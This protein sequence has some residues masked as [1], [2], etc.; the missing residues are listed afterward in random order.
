MMI[1]GHFDYHRPKS[2]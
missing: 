2:V 1:P